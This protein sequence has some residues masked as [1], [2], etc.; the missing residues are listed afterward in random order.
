M[1]V[2]EVPRFGGPEVLVPA[3]SPES[4]LNHP[5]GK[6]LATYWSD[7]SPLPP[8]L[9]GCA[10]VKLVTSPVGEVRLVGLVTAL[11]VDAPG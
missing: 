2:I 4:E 6:C 10:P 5:N 8:A 3:D 7:G 9:A 11:L 1:L